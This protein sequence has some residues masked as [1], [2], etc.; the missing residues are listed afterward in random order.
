MST[1]WNHFKQ[2]GAALESCMP[3]VATDTEPCTEETC[4]KYA[5][6]NG[7]EDIPN[8]VEAIKEKVMNHG[9]VA[10]TFHVYDDFRYYT[11][12]C[13]EHEGDDPINHAVVIIGWN[14]NLCD[15]EGAWL[16]KN[17]WGTDWGMDGYFWIKYGSCNIGYAT[18]AVYYFE[19][20]DIAY[21]DQTVDDSSGDGDGR[22]DAGESVNLTVTLKNE[23]LANLK[24]GI[25]ATIGCSHP[26]VEISSDT[27][28]YP[29]LD[30]GE[31][32]DSHT[33]YQMSFNRLLTVGDLIEFTLNIS[34][35]GGCSRMD[36]FY[37][38]IGDM[39]I[40][41][42]DDDDGATYESYFMQALDNNQYLYDVWNEK[43]RGSPSSSDLAPYFIVIWET[44]TAGRIVST[45]QAA[46][47]SYLDGGGRALFT[48]QDIGWYLNDYSGHTPGD[49]VFY[50]N[51]LHADY[52][53]DDSGYRSLTGVSGDPVG[54]GMS[55]DIGGGD[56]SNNQDWPSEI[57]ARIGAT[58][59]FEYVSG[60]AGGIKCESPHRIV[61][62]AFGFEAINTSADRDLLMQ[63]AVDWL[64]MGALPDTDPPI[65]SLDRPTTGAELWLIGDDE[66]VQW[67]A[68]DNSGTCLIDILLSR[69][70]GA[71]YPETLTTAEPNDGSYL[72]P[73]TGPPSI[74]SRIMVVAYDPD[75]N[76]AADTSEADFEIQYTPADV[77]A[78]SS[79][80]L[81]VLVLLTLITGILI[82]RKKLAA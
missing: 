71:S 25:S 53:L 5:A 35:D 14:D 16:V 43:D 34:A 32:G 20:T 26:W 6:T 68:S 28:T 60:S 47:S 48:G 7:W 10:T 23:I 78:L 73:V 66:D 18:Q 42:V 62:L 46:I 49:V 9:P 81:V 58:E 21:E 8:I 64:A 45:N 39:P 80:G 15:G 63:R 41:L 51:Y 36:T 30:A 56:G 76:C 50:N 1:A 22:V 72:W 67:T 33:P 38:K 40:L 44:G 77:P 29:D 69:D 75:N 24:T 55:F 4:E 12:G 61:Y 31:E 79:W 52:I 65:I 59:V 82:L 70:G 2:Y 19:A 54:N 3:Y 37:V 74:Y 11:E 17:S 57:N 13:Y 27:S